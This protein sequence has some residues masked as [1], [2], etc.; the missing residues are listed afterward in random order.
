MTTCISLYPYLA[1]SINSGTEIY[2]T[3]VDIHQIIL[4]YAQFIVEL[5]SIASWEAQNFMNEEIEKKTNIFHGRII[6]LKNTSRKKTG[7]MGRCSE[8]KKC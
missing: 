6:L 1:S 4:K 7:K 2:R 8:C 5:S 3:D